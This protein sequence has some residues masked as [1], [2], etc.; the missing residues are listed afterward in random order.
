M[1]CEGGLVNWTQHLPFRR[2]AVPCPVVDLRVSG[3][4]T[5]Q[6]FTYEL[7]DRMYSYTQRGLRSGPKTLNAAALTSCRPTIYLSQKTTVRRRPRIH[8]GIQ[9]LSYYSACPPGIRPAILYVRH[10]PESYSA[11]NQ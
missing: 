4:G 7:H 8:R 10:Y 5:T 6:Y 1:A 9:L 11:H 2:R 3:D